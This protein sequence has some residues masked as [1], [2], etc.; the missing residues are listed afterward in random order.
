MYRHRYINKLSQF[1]RTS[2]TLILEDLE[3]SMPMVRIEKEFAASL[4][5]LDEEVF[6]QEASK[7]IRIAQQAYDTQQAEQPIEDTPAGD[8]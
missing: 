6:Y 8:E 2:C 7:E 3:G 5:E 4:E 1:G